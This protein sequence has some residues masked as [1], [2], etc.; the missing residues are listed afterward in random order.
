MKK[1]NG[2]K[3]KTWEEFS[4]LK[5]EI[6]TMLDKKM[7]ND[8][9][10]NL[11]IIEAKLIRDGKTLECKTEKINIPLDIMENDEKDISSAKSQPSEEK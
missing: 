4:R 1:N 10:M 2:I 6:E 5:Q 9:L 3:P 8:Y 11:L 7:D